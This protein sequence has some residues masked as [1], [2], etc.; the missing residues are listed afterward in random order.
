MSDREPPTIH[1]TVD[2][3]GSGTLYIRLR[4]HECRAL[5]HEVCR[6]LQA[7]THDRWHLVAGD[8]GSVFSGARCEIKST[9]N[10]E[11]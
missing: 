8:P 5:M 3:P 6:L 10:M 1:L 11:N 9:K 7:A 2:K 4:G